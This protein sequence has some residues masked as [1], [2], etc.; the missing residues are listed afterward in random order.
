MS[1][2]LRG[3]TW[4]LHSPMSTR[5]FVMASDIRF[6]SEFHCT[7]IITIV[8]VLE[9]KLSSVILALLNSLACASTK[10]CNST[11]SIVKSY[12][13]CCDGF[14][15]NAT[16]TDHEYF[17]KY[18]AVLNTPRKKTLKTEGCPRGSLMNTYN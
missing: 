14:T 6:A 2:K 11:K 13:E 16:S 17:Y 3:P 10:E 4:Y 8:S 12:V 1:A 15:G 7:L 18:Y 9:F 5:N